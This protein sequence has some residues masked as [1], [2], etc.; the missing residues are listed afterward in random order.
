MVH[1][2]TTERRQHRR[3]IVDGKAILRTAAGQAPGSLVDVGAGGILLLSRGAVCVGESLE[4]RFAIQGYPVEMKATGRVAR[5]EPG[6]IG[7]AF[8]ETP[9]DLE[10]ALLWLEAEF[11]AAFL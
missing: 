9:P 8:A 5:T 4:V 11:L 6:V 2:V 7:I 1:T 10:E 3:Y